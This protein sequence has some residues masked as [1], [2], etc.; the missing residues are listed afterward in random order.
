VRRAKITGPRR[1]VLLLACVAG[2]AACASTSPAEKTIEPAAAADT[3]FVLSRDPGPAVKPESVNG[4]QVHVGELWWPFRG[5]YLKI[6]EG[7]ARQRD[8][9]ISERQAPND[10]WDEQTAVETIFIWGTFCNECHGGRRRMEDVVKMPG[11]AANW[12][13][14]EGLFFG[15]RRPYSE[16][17]RTISNGKIER[18]GNRW[19]MPAWRGK[20]S[21]EQIW[22]LIYFIEYQSGGIEG[23]FPPSLYPRGDTAD[24]Q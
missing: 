19:K 11:P 20:L 6:G 2:L 21:N 17:F 1:L 16:I 14:A 9:E 3:S 4:D 12:G 13:R 18:E 15:V 23:R 10:F 8:G 24:R 22:A 7:G 5:K